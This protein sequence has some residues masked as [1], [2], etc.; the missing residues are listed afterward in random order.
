MKLY[1]RLAWRNI[2]RHRLRTLIIVLTVALVMAIS[3]FFD[4]LYAGIR[5]SMDENAIKLLGG[6]IQIHDGEY[7]DLEFTPLIAVP[8]DQEVLTVV[9]DMPEVV[10]ASR[11][12]YTSGLASNREGA[13][14]VSIIG[15]EPEN[16]SSVSLAFQNIDAGR[17]L[18]SDDLD[19]V[20][21]GR[22]LADA[23]EIKVGDRFSLAGL[24]GHEQL[25]NR[26][27]T[28]VGIYDVGMVDFE[29]S[30]LYMSLKE[31]QDLYG[32]TL[33]STEI[34]VWLQQTRQVNK[35]VRELKTKLPD[36][37]INTWEVNYKEF[38]DALEADQFYFS[39]MSIIMI[40]IAA[41]GIFNLLQMAVHERTR[42]IGILG[43][44]GFKQRQITHLF[45]L[46]GLVIGL[47]GMLVGLLLAIAINSIMGQ[48]GMGLGAVSE[49]MEAVALIS[50]RIY[51]TLGLDKFVLR[52]ST[53]LISSLLAS[54]FP[55]RDAA[56]SEPA[57]SL[58]Y[59]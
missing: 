7:I 12:I 25:R 4:G 55:A 52:F 20:V 3:F 53:V 16:E 39:I 38:S 44:L 23:M 21:I 24:S 58:H 41:I 26:S 22:G 13:F 10:M 42:E 1:L 33:Q 2:W 6:N 37:E 59:V 45:L 50:G 27:M 28:V 31:A 48:V 17:A 8:D 14:S 47:S 32:L 46:E 49:M 19:M 5:K 54:Y 18:T 29:K 56:R 43:A 34:A 51:S 36:Y 40:I 30:T 57:K 11:R 9:K 35:V 15:V